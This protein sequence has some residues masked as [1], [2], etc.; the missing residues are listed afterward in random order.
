MN[1]IINKKRVPGAVFA[2][3]K[4]SKVLYSKA[5]GVSSVES[6]K[7]VTTDTLF[8][9]GSTHKAI[10][11]LLIAVLVDEGVLT[12]D[13][14]AQDIYEDFTLSDESYAS[15]ITI[16]QLL[17]MSAG[18]PEKFDNPPS[19]AR[20]LLEELTDIQLKPPESQY[21][22]SNLSVSIAGYLAVLAQKKFEKGSISEDDLET[23]H[24]GY[25]KLLR[26]KVLTPI[27]MK[28]SYLYINEAK[29]TNRMSSSHYLE[30]GRFIVAE[31]EDRTV[32]VFAPAGGLKSTVIDMIKYTMVEEQQGITAEGKR[33]VSKKNMQVR[34]TL[35]KG[36]SS[37]EE[38]GL[39]LE[40][41]TLPILVL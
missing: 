32:D 15:Q 37:E 18:L 16:R 10:T 9:I 24:S 4:E 38:Y 30:E 19:K 40:I 22:Y 29:A 6:Q 34:Q 2:V 13:T 36:V 33:I 17:D 7:K 39:C 35:S 5:F 27:G 8:H 3:A 23:L 20:G 26:E 28:S 11:S 14:K 12:W 31:S 21:E 41:R 25:E 1:D